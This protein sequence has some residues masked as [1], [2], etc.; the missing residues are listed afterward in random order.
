MPSRKVC[1]D[2]RHPDQ[3]TGSTHRSI[4]AHPGAQPVNALRTVLPG[5]TPS[6]TYRRAFSPFARSTVS[7]TVCPGEVRSER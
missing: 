5:W 3:A 7:P 1:W 4:P 6:F 2:A